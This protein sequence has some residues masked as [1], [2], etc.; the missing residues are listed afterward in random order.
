MLQILKE[1][2]MNNYKFWVLALSLVLSQKAFSYPNCGTGSNGDFND[3]AIRCWEPSP[4]NPNIH[5][6]LLTVTRDPNGPNGISGSYPNG[7]TCEIN[8]TSAWTLT[9]SS[10]SYNVTIGTV[11]PVNN[12]Q[13][14]PYC[15]TNVIQNMNFNFAG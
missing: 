13:P 1:T 10:Y 8:G 14:L 11:F 5:H 15:V 6:V 9:P 3:R 4:G 2:K 7:Q 12:W